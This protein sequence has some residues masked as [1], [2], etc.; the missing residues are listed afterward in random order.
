VRRTF[1]LALGGLAL[2]AA[3][4][5]HK[6]PP[7]PEGQ[8]NS[9]RHSINSFR[10]MDPADVLARQSPEERAKTFREKAKQ[11]PVLARPYAQAAQ[12]YVNDP[13]PDV[14]AAAKELIQAAQ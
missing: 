10:S 1:L 14:Q 6:S 4:C 5:G 8:S 3:G 13:D 7:P 2:L 12:K 11:A 9:A